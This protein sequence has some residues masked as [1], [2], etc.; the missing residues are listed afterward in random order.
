M[1][2]SVIG[3]SADARSGR[4]QQLLP[5]RWQWRRRRRPSRGTNFTRRGWSCADSPLINKRG[6]GAPARTALASYSKR[7]PSYKSSCSVIRPAVL[8]ALVVV[9][10]VVVVVVH[11]EIIRLCA[12]D[13]S[14][15]RCRRRT[16]IILY[17]KL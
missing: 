9:I 3:T 8:R 14:H 1:C 10:I 6:S 12:R 5:S 4:L 16:I 2:L 15:A 13:P 17:N 7:M 11:P